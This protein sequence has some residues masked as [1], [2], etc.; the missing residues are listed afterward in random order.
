MA[1]SHNKNYNNLFEANNNFYFYEFLSQL[2]LEKIDSRQ[3]VFI[4]YL[5]DNNLFSPE[6]SLFISKLDK[7]QKNLFYESILKFTYE[8]LYVHVSDFVRNSQ[9]NS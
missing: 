7:V 9:K 4:S 3:E 8:S 1:I 6:T 2:D 5:A